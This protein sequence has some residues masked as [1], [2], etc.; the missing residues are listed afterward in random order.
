MHRG[1]GAE[2][3]HRF[4][5]PWA[6]TAEHHRAKLS[7]VLVADDE[8]HLAV[9]GDHQHEHAVVGDVVVLGVGLKLRL[10]PASHLVVQ[11]LPFRPEA[12]FHRAAGGEDFKPVP[13]P[14]DLAQPRHVQTGEGATLQHLVRQFTI[15]LP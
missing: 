13:L 3:R 15:V 4:C 8:P 14:V 9:A 10:R 7:V 6:G 12:H 11:V 5:H 1:K 2:V